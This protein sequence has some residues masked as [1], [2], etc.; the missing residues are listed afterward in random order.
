MQPLVTA[1]DSNTDFSRGLVSRGMPNSIPS[2]VNTST[3]YNVLS[4]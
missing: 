2:E 4:V 3:T 1:S